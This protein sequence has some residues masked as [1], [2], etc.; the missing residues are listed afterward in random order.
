MLFL[1]LQL[2]VQTLRGNP[3]M[4]LC[5]T[6]QTSPDI[7]PCSLGYIP[8]TLPLGLNWL[9]CPCYCSSLGLCLVPCHAVLAGLWLGPD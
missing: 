5:S 1:G 3:S 6:M 2:H 9:R 4:M 7:L 8:L